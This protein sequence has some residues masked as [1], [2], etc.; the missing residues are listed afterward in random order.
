[1]GIGRTSLVSA[2]VLMVSGA[3]PDTVFDLLSEKRT[4]KVPDT[5]K[6]KDWLLSIKDDLIMMK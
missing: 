1:M 3:S 5:P 6:Q 4:L 2:G